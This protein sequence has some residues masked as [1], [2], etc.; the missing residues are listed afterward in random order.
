[1]MNY[2]IAA[3]G[4]KVSNSKSDQSFKPIK[5]FKTSSTGQEMKPM[6]FKEANVNGETNSGIR[7]DF[8]ECC[9][10]KLCSQFRKSNLVQFMK[11]GFIFMQRNHI[12]RQMMD[13]L[14]DVLYV[15]LLC[16]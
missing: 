7:D 13:N 14:N 9:S 1:M 10:T 12:S 4:F 11:R 8:Q 2:R 15:P 3:I 16:H 5:N 6:Q